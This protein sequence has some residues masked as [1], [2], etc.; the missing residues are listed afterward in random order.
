LEPDVT[1][2][3]PWSFARLT[4]LS[5]GALEG[6]AEELEA[7]GVLVGDRLDATFEQWAAL[8]V[9]PSSSGFE[10]LGASSDGGELRARW[11]MLQRA[12]S[13]AM[14]PIALEVTSEG[15]V[16]A[17]SARL[18]LF[19]ADAEWHP[20]LGFDGW[21]MD[22]MLPPVLAH[23]AQIA[24]EPAASRP[25]QFA[26][27]GRLR[28]QLD[29]AVA[30]LDG[31]LTLELDEHLSSLQVRTPQRFGL[32]WVNRGES[33]RTVSLRLTEVRADG[34]REELDLGAFD[35][36]ST[37][38][39]PSSREHI[40]LPDPVAGVARLARERQGQLRSR[41]EAE[42]LDPAIL[43]PEG[44]EVDEWLDLSHYA[45][46]VVGF[47]RVRR[48]SSPLRFSGEL[49]SS[50]VDA[51]DDDAFLSLRFVGDAPDD[52]KTLR[53]ETPEAATRFLEEV[54]QV[55][56]DS[57]GA[58]LLWESLEIAPD[59]SLRA[60]VDRAVSVH[61]SAAAAAAAQPDAL[62]DV[63]GP[64]ALAVVIEA[65]DAS[66][67]YELDGPRCD[68][69]RV[70]FALLETLLRP[71][72][73]LKPHQ[74]AGVAWLWNHIE[75]G[76]PGVL[77]ADDMGLGKT[78]QVACVLA[79]RLA[80]AP[81]GK[82]GAPALVVA[83]TILLDNWLVEIERFFRPGVF[84]QVVLLHGD[85]LQAHRTS[86]GLDTERIQAA[87]LVL[88]N[89]ETLARY[90]VSLLRVDFSVVAFDEA[91]AIKN[92]STLRSRA[93][94]GLKRTFAV[95]ITGTPVENRLKDLWAI[96]E[97]LQPQR[98]QRA[99][100]T[101][102]TFEADYERDRVGGVERLRERLGFPSAASVV[103]RREKAK[104]LRDLPQKVMHERPVEMTPHQHA[105]ERSIVR[106]MR[107]QGPLG[108]LDK[109]RKLYQHPE[110]VAPRA[111][112]RLSV[113]D[114]KAQSPKVR[115]TL[116]I[117]DDV[118]R[119]GEKAIVF[120]QWVEM[121]D[122]LQRVIRAEFGLPRV[123][124]INGDPVL[125]ARATQTIARFSATPG[126]DVLVLSPLAAGVGLTITAANHVIHY[127][128]WWNPA[129]EDQATDR[130]HRI[131]QTREVHVYYPL[132]HHPGAPQA[133][134]DVRLHELVERKRAVARDFLAPPQDDQLERE[135]LGV[136]ER[137]GEA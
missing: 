103:L 20:K 60:T 39:S 129:K 75:A 119:L 53:L 99:F 134:F 83:P 32:E 74:R 1:K 42:I 24:A 12:L 13:S 69:T 52:T 97:A 4:Q 50:L 35:P 21:P 130:A 135:L 43:F 31:R 122:L 110:L 66:D 9:A 38:V 15:Y 127:G 34:G 108:V 131:G 88:T 19:V 28:A 136:L 112:P 63:A 14:A 89:Y 123:D 64:G 33:G 44:S 49:G 56:G 105:L 120:T 94:Q 22:A 26:R 132:L 84:G 68:E 76:T 47:E 98:E 80:A 54:D 81:R 45:D 58:P 111:G 37:V 87:A 114:A 67:D 62:A 2:R 73:A 92:E 61:R 109:L 11:A 70:P 85:A 96:F 137:E 125:R 128:R 95:A 65:R 18:R 51:G 118:R 106:S 10:D 117:L 77:L 7:R 8:G 93:A 55:L 90:Q 86:R 59:A 23:A 17:N 124:L 115:E 29:A 5:Q 79:M 121:Q 41:K 71:G 16:G 46:R 6:F 126:F 116:A 30:A 102:A 57:G 104:A 72:I 25:A 107:Q 82:V 133:G 100:G 113:E 78:L 36:A 40:L 48:G 3:P 101:R 27:W 91:Q